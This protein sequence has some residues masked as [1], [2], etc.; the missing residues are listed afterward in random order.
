M[1]KVNVAVTV[2]H[3]KDG[4]MEPLA[5]EWHDGRVFEIDKI[6]KSYIGPVVRSG[7]YGHIFICRVRNK[8]VFLYHEEMDNK[9]YIETD[10]IKE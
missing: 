2:N 1:N 4:T 7:G 10:K 9:W 3:Y 5:I 8:E 6:I